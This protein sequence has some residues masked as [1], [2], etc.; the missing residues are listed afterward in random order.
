MPRCSVYMNKVWRGPVKPSFVKFDI[1]ITFFY[2]F[3]SHYV[4]KPTRESR[5]HQK[6]CK[7]F[8]QM[9]AHSLHL[10]PIINCVSHRQRSNARFCPNLS[11]QGTTVSICDLKLGG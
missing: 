7:K 5:I 2:V 10:K 4:E 6:L 1:V 9:T 8:T 11:T 3:K